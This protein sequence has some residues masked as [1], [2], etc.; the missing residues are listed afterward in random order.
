MDETTYLLASPANARLLRE[1]IAALN[2]GQG[3]PR[4]LIDE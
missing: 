4:D 2:A 1:G 3:Q